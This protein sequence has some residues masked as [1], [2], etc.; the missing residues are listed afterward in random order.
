MIYITGDTHANFLR[1]SNHQFPD[2]R[3]MTKNDCVIICGDFGGVWKDTPEERYWLDWLDDKP[4]T[5]LYV[6]GNH[7]NFD[8]YYSNEFQDVKYCGGNAQ[9]I[10]SS[11]FHL[12]RGEVFRIQG[13][14]FFAFGG[15]SSHDIRD[16][17]L[18]IDDF[19]SEAE[20]RR[21][22]RRMRIAGKQFRV[23]HYSW[24]A[25]EMASDEE[26]RHG[27]EMLAANGNAVDYVITHCLPQE[28]AATFSMGLYK[29]DTLTMYFNKL[30]QDGLSFDKWY[31]GH[32]HVNRRIMGKFNILYDNIERIL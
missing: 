27:V 1:F 9:R 21:V 26:M 13:K 10:R 7:E 16:G 32:Y 4:F 24:W 19:D 30:L 14:R 12:K 5:T 18:D 8:R 22:H 6:D 2:Q 31:C 17:I 15:A 20:F 29:S 23:N 11:I 25:Q 3:M 28:V